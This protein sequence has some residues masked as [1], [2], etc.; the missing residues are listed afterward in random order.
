MIDINAMDFIQSFNLKRATIGLV[1]HGFVGRAVEAFFRDAK[2]NEPK[3]GKI[4]INDK[5]K[6]ELNTLREVVAESE[7][8]FVAVPTPMRQDGS[9]YTGFVEEVIG[10]VNAT[11]KELQRNLDSFIVVVKSTVRPGFTEEMQDK[12]L[13]MRV[14]FSPE[15]LTEKNSIEDFRKTNRIIVGGDQEDALVVCKYFMDA[16]PNPVRMNTRYILQC[17]P[18]V[19]EMTKLFANG[20]LTAKVIFSNEVYQIC[21]KIGISYDEVRHLAALDPRVGLFHTQVPGP[22]GNLGY[23]GHCFPKDIQ[24][25]RA[26]AKECGVPEKMFTA[27]IERNAEVREDKDWEQMKDRAVTNN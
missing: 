10:H 27:M 19:A 6:P 21:E 24:N 20:M 12:Y 26:V 7:V 9:C 17:D 22:D 8:I 18:T 5:A 14:C 25:L 4:L 23:G 11:A 13:P 1:G 15:F 16:D 3:V 2:T